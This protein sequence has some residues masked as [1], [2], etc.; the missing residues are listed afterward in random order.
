MF[1]QGELRILAGSVALFLA[2]LGWRAAHAN[3][4]LPPLSVRGR[5]LEW[6]EPVSHQASLEAERPAASAVCRTPATELVTRLDPNIAS[7]AQLES[8][9]G[10]GPA[11]AKRILEAR[12]A[13][14]FRSLADLDRVKGIGPSKLEKLGPHLLF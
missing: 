4:I 7:Q 9:P 13:S 6:S 8:M 10:I 5:I 2:G 11:L 1:H 14:P 3:E 12:A